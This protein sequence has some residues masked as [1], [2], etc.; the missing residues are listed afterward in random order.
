[1]GQS[2]RRGFLR[3]GLAFL[4]LLGLAAT[5]GCDA[6]Y[7]VRMDTRSG[8]AQQ[9]S[10]VALGEGTAL[11]GR[12]LTGVEVDA[13]P[14]WGAGAGQE[15]R[16]VTGSDGTALLQFSV[17]GF[18]WDLPAVDRLEVEFTCRRDGYTPV[19]GSFRLAGFHG[20]TPKQTVLVVM[21]PNAAGAR[22]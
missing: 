11:A 2:S 18:V 13:Q 6:F 14:T 5:V 21:A 7:G 4:L 12:P 9:M 22:E 19:T 8:D 1:M 3:A 10:V 17:G 15:V 16:L 20:T